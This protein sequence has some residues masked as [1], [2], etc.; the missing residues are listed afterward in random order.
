METIHIYHSNDLHSHF[1]HWES[2]RQLLQDR[3]AWHEQEGDDVFVFDIGDHMDRWHP[4]SDATRGKGNCQLLNEAGYDAITIGNNEG[5]TLSY[6]NLDEMYDERAFHV[7]AANLYNEDGERPAWAN[8]YQ[9]YHS[10][11]GKRIAAIGLTVNYTH[12]YDLLGWKVTDPYDELEKALRELAGKADVFLLLSHLGLH[13]DEKI[14]ELFPEIDVIIGGHTH[15]ILHEGKMV[16]DTLICGAGKYGQF[17]GHITIELNEVE[18]RPSAKKAFLY[19]MTEQ[20]SVDDTEAEILYHTGK[21][22]LQ[23]PVKTLEKPIP[24]DAM[25]TQGL[26]ELL[27]DELKQFTGGDVAFLNAGL[28]LGGLQNT[29]TEYDL[30]SVCPHPINPCTVI[31]TGAELK[32]VLLQAMT[33]KWTSMQIRGL[34]FRGTVMGKMVF[35]G[36]TKSEGM[37]VINGRS[38]EYKA[39]YT[40]AIPD[41]FTFG[42]FFPE[43]YRCTKKQYFLPDFMRDLLRNAILKLE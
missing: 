17:I 27:C 32:E 2:I 42:R 40:V 30:L 15:H 16:G 33:D 41:M 37:F 26:P 6:E 7:L 36:V 13:E 18:I 21:Q 25:A 1:E 31:L 20:S 43:I 11:S 35:S 12:F 10:K 5:I 9:I 28:L 8:P 23:T 3:R 24:G 4:Y 19:D 14:A 22:L 38:L 29:V 34:G 39:E